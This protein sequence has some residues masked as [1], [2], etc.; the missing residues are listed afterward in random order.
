M[1]SMTLSID[2]QTRKRMRR[3][4]QIKWSEVARSAIRRQL[5]DIEEAERIASHSMLTEKDVRQIAG[6]ADRE[7]LKHFE[8]L[9]HESDG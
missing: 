6:R 5:D 4:P 1:V 8:G 3:H 2:E 7:M 9:A